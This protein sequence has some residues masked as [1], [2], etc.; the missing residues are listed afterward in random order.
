[1]IKISVFTPTYNRKVCLERVYQSLLRQTDKKFYWI[2]I[3]DGS[4]DDTYQLV[5]I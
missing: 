4:T 3:D 1:M 5:E 2:I